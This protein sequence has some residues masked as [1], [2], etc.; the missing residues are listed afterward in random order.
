MTT[1]TSS[2]KVLW[3]MRILPAFMTRFV[4]LLRSCVDDVTLAPTCPWGSRSMMMRFLESCSWISTTF[5]TPF[6]TK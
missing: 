3:R 5:S 4:L 2:A 1:G 6:T